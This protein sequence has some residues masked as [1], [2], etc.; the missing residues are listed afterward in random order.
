MNRD[1]SFSATPRDLDGV[2]PAAEQVDVFGKDEFLC[3]LGK[4][5]VVA[6][7]DEDLNAYL[8]QTAEL[9]GEKARRLHRGLLAV[10]KIAGQQERI[11][12]FVEAQVDDTRENLPAGVADEFR[13]PRIA[14]SERTQRR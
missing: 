12:L 6:P 7:D 9:L 4:G 10:V 11:Y 1:R 2:G 13:Q 14:Q 8:V 5:V 3:Y